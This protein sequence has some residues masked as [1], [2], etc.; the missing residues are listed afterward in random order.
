[1]I[2]E[3]NPRINIQGI[4]L[5]GEKTAFSCPFYTVK[6]QKN[7][8]LVDQKIKEKMLNERNNQKMSG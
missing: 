6:S 4:K 3:R 5:N 1:M 8:M 7:M 2:K